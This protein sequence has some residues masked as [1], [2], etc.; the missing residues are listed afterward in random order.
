MIKDEYWKY[1]D[2]REENQ[3][4]DNSRNSIQIWH[5]I[6]GFEKMEEFEHIQEILKSSNY[7]I[8]WLIRHWRWER[9]RVKKIIPNFSATENLWVWDSIHRV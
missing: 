6:N 8:V 4:G 3:L 7:K 9:E 2:W 5:V 1:K